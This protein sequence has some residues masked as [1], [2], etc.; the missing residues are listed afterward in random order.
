MEVTAAIL[1]LF[2]LLTVSFTAAGYY[3][4]LRPAGVR[5]SV[6]ELLGSSAAVAAQP[7]PPLFDV[8][9]LLARLGKL[10]PVSPVNAGNVRALLI[11][12]GW[13]S[14]QAPVVFTGVQL[15]M[16]LVLGLASITFSGVASGST[17]TQVLITT[18]GLLAG[19]S[20]PRAILRSRV[21]ARQRRI[22]LSLPDALDLIVVCVEAGLGL[23][24]AMI[25]VTS[26]LQRPHP[27]LID[28]F[29]VLN[30]EMRAG[31]TRADAFRNLATRTGEEDLSKLVAVLIQ[32]DRFGTS[33]ADSLRTHAEFMR[34][35]RKQLAEERA[36][37]VGVKLVLPIFFFI[38]PAMMV[39]SVG[40]G[41]LQLVKNLMPM[42][43]SVK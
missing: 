6:V 16:S 33:I 39:V 15:A 41:A 11:S 21:R 26:Q 31:K 36:A 13:R 4:Y 12:A 10:I 2:V 9:V 17:M 24:Q 25:N 42:M 20:L 27:D 8:P 30:A 35:R 32:A 7:K 37:K 29:S 43:Q 22:R 18:G 23:D 40:P 5:A 19:Y 34:M 28:E 38:M 14:E 3:M 1:I